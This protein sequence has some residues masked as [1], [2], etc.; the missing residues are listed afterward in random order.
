MSFPP[1]L[2]IRTI[3]LLAFLFA[4]GVPLALF[5]TWPHTSFLQYQM[6]EVRDRQQMLARSLGTSLET[7]QEDLTTALQSFAPLIADGRGEEV[8]TTLE[9][10][11]FTQICVMQPNTGA[12]LRGFL[13]TDGGCP[14]SLADDQREMVLDLAG[15]GQVGISGV[16][17]ND[18]DQPRIYLAARAYDVVIYATVSTQFFIDLHE[19]LDFGDQ[20]YAAIVDRDGLVLAHPV[21]MLQNMRADLSYLPPVQQI[22]AGE[23]G[24]AGFFDETDQA[25]MIAGFASVSG[26]GWGVFVPR[27]LSGLEAAAQRIT[28]EGLMI[29]AVALCLSVLL[30]LILARFFTRRVRKVEA[31][32]RQMADGDRS[33]RLRTQADWPRLRELDQMADSFNRMADRLDTAHQNEVGLRATAEQA[34]RAKSEF[35]TNIS[36]EIRTPMNGILGVT[37]ALR[38]GDLTPKQARQLDVVAESG[39]QLLTVLDDILDFS[40]IESGNLEIQSDAF[41]LIQTVLTV[42]RLMTP[43][44]RRKGLDVFAR[45]PPDMSGIVIGDGPRIRQ[46]LLN[47]VGNAV[48]FTEQG[49]VSIDLQM[50][51]V[52]DEQLS[53]QIAVTD[54]GVGISPERMDTIFGAFEQSGDDLERPEGT[55]LG[56]AIC[57]R[58]TTA[59]NGALTVEAELDKGSTFQF[60]VRLPAGSKL[61]KA[62]AQAIGAFSDLRVMVV[63]TNPVQRRILVDYLTHLGLGNFEQITP[64]QNITVVSGKT[65]S[66]QFVDV[67]I[68]DPAG[69]DFT[70]SDI[71]R[72]M[73]RH[74]DKR[75]PRLILLEQP[76][77][78]ASKY[79][80]TAQIIETPVVPSDLCAALL[81]VESA[82]PSSDADPRPG[83][84]R[85]FKRSGKSKKAADK[86]RS[87]KPAKKQV[88][89]D[90]DDLIAERSSADSKTGAPWAVSAVPDDLIGPPMPTLRASKDPHSATVLV[91]ERNRSERSATGLVLD[92]VDIAARFAP[93]GKAAIRQLAENPDIDAV[94]LDI[95]A[96]GTDAI[97]TT[98]EIAQLFSGAEG[99]QRKIIG[100]AAKSPVSREREL[101]AAGMTHL[102][103]KPLKSAAFQRIL[104][105]THTP[106]EAKSVAQTA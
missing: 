57:S 35:L 9:S 42:A 85:L 22:Q 104:R 1:I 96:P 81:T 84:T 103:E 89:S 16:T 67:M 51:P 21:E 11:H 94:I 30:G 46:V 40:T 29:L 59:M 69:F 106:V 97:E 10:L 5:W 37:D 83:N 12:I 14:E 71:Q 66:D 64:D 75:A 38:Q 77:Q 70:P 62:E 101:R 95:D 36:H 23:S 63:A 31:T 76:G 56:L 48:K 93:N 88:V 102:L 25:E 17:L 47:L 19:S 73:A 87:K 39:R 79:A 41:D 72:L 98:R 13:E 52:D 58:I 91:I 45:V 2:T 78:D 43:E 15:S 7:Y 34:S 74:S 20:G 4:A 44:A 8:R 24:V 54:T 68:Y 3:V 50:V 61:N 18:R 100:L 32:T 80:A 27:P 99:T 53:V 49:H 55:G 60:T 33:A 82:G 92:E 90:T 65:K 6:S 86:P 26:A 28:R 105:D